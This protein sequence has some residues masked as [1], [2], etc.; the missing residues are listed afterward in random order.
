M[1]AGIGAVGALGVRTAAV[2]PWLRTAGTIIAF[3]DR[4]FLSSESEPSSSA[5]SP[6]IS[7]GLAPSMDSDSDSD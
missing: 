7:S 6:S 2:A 5:A 1:R 3:G 4:G